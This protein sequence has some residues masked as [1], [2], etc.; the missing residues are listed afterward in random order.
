MSTFDHSKL[1]LSILKARF[2]LLLRLLTCLFLALIVAIGVHISP[3]YA[4][5]DEV[6]KGIIAKSIEL[7]RKET[8]AFN[9]MSASEIARFQALLEEGAMYADYGSFSHPQTDDEKQRVDGSWFYW[10][11]YHD[12]YSDTIHHYGKSDVIETELGINIGNPD[13]L[14]ANVYA[15]ELFNLAIRFYPN[16]SRQYLTYQELRPMEGGYAEAPHV[17]A[18]E[19]ERIYFGTVWPGSYP[20]CGIQYQ[21]I[22]MDFH[23]VTKLFLKNRRCPS[24]PT[25]IDRSGNTE[26]VPQ[27]TSHST[28]YLGWALHMVAD[29]T[30][31]YHSANDASTSHPWWEEKANEVWISFNPM[32][33]SFTLLAPNENTPLTPRDVMKDISDVKI[34]VVND[35]NGEISEVTPGVFVPPIMDADNLRLLH[36]DLLKEA[37]SRTASAIYWYLKFTEIKDGRSLVNGWLPVNSSA[38]DIGIGGDRSVWALG[39]S[40]DNQ[41]NSQVYKRSGSEWYA[42]N[43]AGIGIDVDPIGTP[44]IFNRQGEIYYKNRIE[45]Q[46]VKV[47]GQARGLGI[48]GDGSVWILGWDPKTDSTGNLIGYQVSKWNGSGWDPYDAYGVAID[49]APGGTPWMTNGQGEIS[50]LDLNNNQWMK[51]PGRARQIGIGGDRSVWIVGWDYNSYMAGYPIYR[52]SGGSWK[53]GGDFGVAVDVAPGGT[54]WIANQEGRISYLDQSGEILYPN[55]K[56][57]SYIAEYGE[58]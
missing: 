1:K 2:F 20:N 35:D 16:Y 55:P 7:L 5:G 10:E 57:N 39:Y 56:K 17:I 40:A 37:V 58:P 18:P 12:D 27:D 28:R 38:R 9:H 26:R 33:Q 23:N 41:G 51:V 24:W 22:W 32:L 6:H 42:D 4:Y 43:A 3:A 30:V 53:F 52:L 11:D 47:P 15:Q 48:G 50:Y 21:V 25:W 14:T 46:W 45:D 49:V 29:L 8:S 13:Q 19:G 36:E 31:P 54:P 44:W 34:E